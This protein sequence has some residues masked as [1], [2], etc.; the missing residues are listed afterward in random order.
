LQT[1]LLFR[2]YISAKLTQTYLHMTN[3]L[4]KPGSTLMLRAIMCLALFIPVALQ[5]QDL[6]VSGTVRSDDQA[7]LPGVYVLVKGTSTGAVTDADGKFAIVSPTEGTLVFSFIGMKNIEVPVGGRTTIDVVMET[8]VAQL[9][10]VVVVGYGTQ[11]KTDVTGSVASVSSKE[12][13]STPITG[14]A[15]AMQGRAAGVQV[16]QVSSAPGGGVSVR[17]RGGNSLRGNNEPLYVIDGFPILAENGPTIN[18]NDIESIDIL[19]DASATAIYGSRGANGV[20]IIT[21]KR[22]K[23]GKTNLSF[24]SYYG[25]QTV[26][27]K[28]D[29]LDATQLAELINEGI[30]NTNA[31]NIGKPGFPKAPAFTAEQI[32]A[33]GKGTNW[34]DEIF[35]SA[36]QQNYQLSVSGGDDKNQFMISGNYFKQDGIVLNSNYERGS[37][38]LNLDRKLSKR[39]KFSNSLNFTRTSGNAVNTDNDGGANAGVVYGALNFSPTV[40]VFADDG[41]YT[42]DNRLGAIKISNP[43]ALAELT[44]N[45]STTNRFLGNISGDW[46]IIEGLTLRVLLGANIL[47]TKNAQYV[48][49]TVYAGAG[50]GGTSAIT[51]TESTNWLNENTL[52][53]QKSFNDV[54]KITALL[55]YTVQ[56]FYS[57]DYRASAQ[58]FPNDIVDYNNL[59]YA[60]QVNPSSSGSNEWGLRSYIARVNYDYDERYLVTLTTRVDGS[61]RFGAGNKNAVFPSGSVAWRISKENFMSEVRPVSDLKIR[62]GVGVTGNQEIPTFSSLAAL[63]T[64]NYNFG[65][66]LSVGYAPTRIANPDLKWEP[67]AQTNI[68]IDVGLFTNRIVITADYYNKKTSDLLYDVPLPTSTGYSTSLQNVGQIGNHGFEFSLSTVNIDRAFKWN[69]NFNIS[70]N[71]NEILDL[72]A[73]TGDVPSG[74]ASG[75]LQLSNSGILRVGEPLG[76]F[77]GLETDGIFQNQAEID[78]SAQKTAKPGD[79]RYKDNNPDGVIN[80]AD[81]VILGYAQPKFSFGFTNNFSY[82]GFDLTVFFQGVQGNSIFNINKYELESMT[83]VSNQSTAVLD[84]WTPTNPSNTIP[85]ATSTGAPYQVTDHQIEDGSYIRLKNIQLAYNFSGPVLEKLKIA[86]ARLY[87]SG[88]NIFTITDYSGFDPEVSRFGA[89]AFSFG[90]DYGSYPVAKMYL[91]GCVL[92]F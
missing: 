14:L 37:I 85:R 3:V 2:Q 60:Q 56:H 12:I 9:D 47:N 78:A 46:D 88:Q 16:S 29:L 17:I 40:P 1:T 6:T 63:G 8:D 62:V 55:G 28:L 19:K 21:T 43:V 42:I 68:G 7:P 10:E 27:K 75:H 5:A 50:A 52:T 69:T 22:G 74:Q 20:V 30:A 65:N 4:R 54:H 35:R 51:S 48:P 15:Q 73:V 38:R 32:A 41:S 92:T 67:T 72:G 86:S 82:K 91:V 13:K 39:F 71:R 80:A 33:L 58:N 70:T 84:R 49:R 26:R 79:R 81:R 23:A 45:K 66:N 11:K 59:G 87:V 61:S 76:V 77:Y 83:G 25:V 53:Y 57:E 18:P 64:A 34:Q 31:D 89:D 24:E 44:T 90:T 36:P